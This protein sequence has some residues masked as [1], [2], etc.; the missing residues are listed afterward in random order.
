MQQKEL[1]LIP[2]DKK[3]KGGVKSFFFFDTQVKRFSAESG[4]LSSGV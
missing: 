1:F 2:R 3:P 4:G